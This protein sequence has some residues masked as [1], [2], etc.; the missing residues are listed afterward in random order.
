MYFFYF[1][2]F[3]LSKYKHGNN[4]NICLI[5]RVFMLYLFYWTYCSNVKR[6]LLILPPP[7]FF[8][9]IRR[10]FHRSYVNWSINDFFVGML[11]KRLLY[12]LLLYPSKRP[13]ILLMGFILKIISNPGIRIVR[14][15]FQLFQIDWNQHKLN[16]RQMDK[17]K[18]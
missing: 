11:I 7:P 14:V 18:K 10:S 5:E 1:V 17:A 15:A 16:T 3:L 13:L 2:F 6:G 4:W 12:F 9:E 8:F